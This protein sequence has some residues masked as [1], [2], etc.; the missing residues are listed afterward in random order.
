MSAQCYED[1]TTSEKVTMFGLKVFDKGH[2]HYKV[3]HTFV[4]PHLLTT[5]I[6]SKYAVFNYA[7]TVSTAHVALYAPR[8]VLLM[9]KV[10]QCMHVLRVCALQ[11]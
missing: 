11:S 10:V 3:N 9:A 2:E 6:G 1:L 8:S 7:C 5:P 4:W